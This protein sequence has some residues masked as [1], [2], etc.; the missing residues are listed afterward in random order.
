[1]SLNYSYQDLFEGGRTDPSKQAL[2]L[3]FKANPVPTVDTGCEGVAEFHFLDEN[4]VLFALN[5]SIY[6]MERTRN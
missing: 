2:A 6:R 5:N 4:T 1:M 3:G